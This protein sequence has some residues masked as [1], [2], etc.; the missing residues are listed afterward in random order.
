MG[1]SIQR[2][3]DIWRNQTTGPRPTKNGVRYRSELKQ[4]RSRARER[5]AKP[6]RHS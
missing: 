1:A 3:Q 5:I 4:A 2:D 6:N